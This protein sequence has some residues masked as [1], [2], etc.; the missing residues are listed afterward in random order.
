MTERL[1]FHFS[2]SCIGEGH[3]NPLQCSCLENPR[4]REAWWAAVYGL[5]QSRT[6]LKRLSSSSMRVLWRISMVTSL[7]MFLCFCLLLNTLTSYWY[8]KPFLYNLFCMKN[9]EVL[10]LSWLIDGPIDTIILLWYTNANCNMNFRVRTVVQKIWLTFDLIRN[11]QCWAIKD[12]LW[13][14]LIWNPPE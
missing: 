12:L 6:W 2:L 3:G 8:S 13:P 4:D 9:H 1:H 7:P 10:L 14:H 11:N 5:T